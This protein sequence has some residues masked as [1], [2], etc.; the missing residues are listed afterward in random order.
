MCFHSI[1]KDNANS[2]HLRPM[3]PYIFKEN[4]Y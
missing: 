3:D 4:K 1:L 2:E